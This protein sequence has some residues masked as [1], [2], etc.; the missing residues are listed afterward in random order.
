MGGTQLI[1]RKGR[2]SVVGTSA[3][4]LLQFHVWEDSW[5]A[6][7]TWE[8]VVG[9][10]RERGIIR[11]FGLS[12]NRWEPTNA[13][14]A[15]DTGLVD[16]VQVIY[17]IFDQAPEDDL[18]PYT[19]EHD[20][21]VIARVPFDEGSLTGN[22]SADSRWPEGDWRNSYFVPE[23]LVPTVERVEALRADL[24]PT[25]SLPDV[26]L[27]FILSHPGVS[28]V[29]PGMRRPAHVRQNLAASGRPLPTGVLETLR[30]HRWDRK[31]TWWSQ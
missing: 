20:I 17:N 16:A 2:E 8:H 26:A 23:N 28:T 6:D 14:H 31:P 22:L 7:L 27:R 5:A 9:M 12:I 30:R 10:L 1:S 11:G 13:L 18:F 4:D 3:I 25:E 15:L 24:P 19:M 29:I 21:A